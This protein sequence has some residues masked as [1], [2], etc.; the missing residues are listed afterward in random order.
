MRSCSPVYIPF[1]G[2]VGM[3]KVMKNLAAL[4][5]KIKNDKELTMEDK[6]D[7]QEFLIERIEM[8]PKYFSSV[9][10]MKTQLTILEQLCTPEDYAEKR[11][12]LD[13]QRRRAHIMATMSI[14][15]INKLCK[16][17]E[18]EAIFQFP[19]IGNRELLPEAKNK[20]NRVEEMQASS[21]RELAADAVYGFCKEV[22]LDGK[23]RSLYNEY[24]CDRTTRDI[25]L[26][27]IGNDS[28]FFSTSVQLDD[29]IDQAKAE[30]E[31]NQTQRAP[32]HDDGYR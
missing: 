7:M 15:Q 30:T 12:S 20:G 14:N 5:E 32:W 6:Q 8:F 17:Y 2:G 11:M 21:D 24:D 13:E 31:D 26:F 28:G 23:S 27:H 19:E 9:V 4:A 1:N 10:N 18:M 29:L 25:D 22:F 16:S 3:T